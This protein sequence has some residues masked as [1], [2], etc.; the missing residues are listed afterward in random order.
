MHYAVS[1]IH[2]CYITFRKLLTTI[3]FSDNDTL[4]VLGDSLDRGKY[5]MEVLQYC[6]KHKNIIHLLGNH[7]HMALPK[8]TRVCKTIEGLDE[9][10]ESSKYAFAR[11]AITKTDS[12][13]YHGWMNNGGKSTLTDFIFKLSDEERASVIDYITHMPLYIEHTADGKEYVMT[14]SGIAGNVFSPDKPLSA[15]TANDLIWTRPNMGK[16]YYTDKYMLFGHTPTMII[17]FEGGGDIIQS[18]NNIDI[19]CGCVFGKKLAA[20][21]LETQETVYQ[22]NIEYLP[23]AFDD[24]D[25]Q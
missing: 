25:K 22:A 24:M 7:E 13:E 5:P 23:N 19:D 18:H 20:F 16:T 12:F 1:D 15:Y 4:Y 8:L 14:H 17:S 10:N 9:Y 6:M 11:R 2:G 3:G 21:C